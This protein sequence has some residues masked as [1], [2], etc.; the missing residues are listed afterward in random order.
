MLCH[1]KNMVLLLF[2]IQPQ[3]D[4]HHERLAFHWM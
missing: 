4:T 3:A 2:K 1:T